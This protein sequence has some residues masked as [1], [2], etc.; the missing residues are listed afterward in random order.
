MLT[1]QVTLHDGSEVTVKSS[2]Q[3]LKEAANRMTLEEYSQRCHVPVKTIE[4]LG[5]ALT[6]MIEKPPSS[7]IWRYDGGN[8]SHCMVSYHA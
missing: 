1:R 7:L 5:K 4:S 8:G 6:L 2:F 3:C